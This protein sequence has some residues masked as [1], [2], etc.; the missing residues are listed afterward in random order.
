MA[1]SSLRQVDFMVTS[2]FLSRP[3]NEKSE[4]PGATT[5]FLLTYNNAKVLNQ[6]DLF[7][8]LSVTSRK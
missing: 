1:A 2:P 8:L 6:A 7:S 5:D 4:D 3:R